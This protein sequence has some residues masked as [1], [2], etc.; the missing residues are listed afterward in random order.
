[1]RT[2]CSFSGKAAS[3]H[4]SIGTEFCYC[5]DLLGREKRLFVCIG[6]SAC[7]SNDNGASILGPNDS[8]ENSL[9][10]AF[11]R[12][13]ST[14]GKLVSTLFQLARGMVICPIQPSCSISRVWAIIVK[15]LSYHRCKKVKDLT[16]DVSTLYTSSCTVT[17][18]SKV[19]SQYMSNR[20]PRTRATD[21]LNRNVPLLG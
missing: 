2:R 20:L 3:S 16:V 5:M 18:V 6:S 11:S 1:M 17:A 7:H 15:F 12:W 19:G 21:R 14:C 8:V 13:F 10:F 4:I 9:S